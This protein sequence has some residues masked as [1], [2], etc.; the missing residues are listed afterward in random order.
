MTKGVVCVRIVQAA[1]I[2]RVDL[3]KDAVDE[4]VPQNA[5]VGD[6]IERVG[7]RIVKASGEATCN[8]L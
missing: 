8:L 3:K 1:Q 5:A 4:A 7:V 6:V 2:E